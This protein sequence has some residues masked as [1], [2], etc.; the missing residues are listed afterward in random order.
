MS[1]RASSVMEERTR[2]V[3]EYERGFHRMTELCRMYGIARET[4]YYWL[5][6]FRGGG[7]GGRAGL[8][9]QP[10]NHPRQ[11]GGGVERGGVAFGRARMGCGTGANRDPFVSA[12][13]E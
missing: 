2:F 7:V 13:A 8:G 1:W 3:L 5:R 10:R 12:R 9:R 11:T 6:R 4:G